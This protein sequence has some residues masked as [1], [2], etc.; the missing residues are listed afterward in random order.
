MLEVPVYNT[1]G[2][3]VDTLKVDE[4]VFGGSVNASLVK[5]AV[6]AHHANQRQG[7]AATKSRGQKAG[8][9][10]KIFR[11]KGTGNARRGPVRSPVVRGGGM[12]F[13]KSQRSFHKDMPRK[14]RKAALNSAILA[15]ILGEDLLV[16]DA[17]TADEPKTAV[18]A[19][20]MKNLQVNRSCLLALADRDQ[21]VYLSAR[22]LPDI[23]VRITA[24]LNAAEIATR[25]KM[26]ITAEAMKALMGQEATS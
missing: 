9:T 7:T 5:Q 24:E 3:K 13:A 22:N 16:L 12:A 2:K 20:V 25:Q 21:N 10:R 15:K 11:Q 17:L 14:M 4:S 6:V 23:T 8:S 26:V 18:I 19:G 1:D